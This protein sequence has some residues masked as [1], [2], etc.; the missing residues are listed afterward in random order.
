M[1]ASITVDCMAQK[2]IRTRFSHSDVCFPSFNTI[3]NTEVNPI[4]HATGVKGMPLRMYVLLYEFGM[5]VFELK[6]LKRVWRSSSRQQRTRTNLIQSCKS[7][8]FLDY[9]QSNNVMERLLP[10]DI[11]LVRSARPH[12]FSLTEHLPSSLET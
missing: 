9:W 7:A 2:G 8:L 3:V 1:T 11:G 6:V 10:E 5:K 12:S 4:Q